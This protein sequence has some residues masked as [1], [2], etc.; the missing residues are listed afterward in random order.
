MTEEQKAAY[1]YAQAVSALSE[2]EAMKAANMI[3][4]SQ[5]KALAYGEEAF[6]DIPN[7][8]GIHHNA[9]ISLFHNY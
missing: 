4:E 8:Y 9:T 5:G 6:A 2:I 1:V 3:R 7:R